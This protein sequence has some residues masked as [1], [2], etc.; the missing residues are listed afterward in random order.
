[1][2]LVIPQNVTLYQVGDLLEGASFKNFLD[3][4]DGSY[5]TYLGGDDK[6]QDGIYPD[7]FGEYQGPENCVSGNVFRTCDNI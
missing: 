2:T 5:C 4:I 3:A 1:M 7:P 6:T